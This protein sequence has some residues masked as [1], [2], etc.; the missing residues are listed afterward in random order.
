[1][2][3]LENRRTY[4]DMLFLFKIFNNSDNI[5]SLFPIH[6]PAKC[7]RSSYLFKLPQSNTNNYIFSCINRIMS[8]NN[9]QFSNLDLFQLS[10]NNFKKYVKSY[11]NLI[12]LSSFLL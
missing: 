8:V 11:I 7:T 3:S 5:I 6:V 10:L 4:F 12:S 1:M 2:N 9:N